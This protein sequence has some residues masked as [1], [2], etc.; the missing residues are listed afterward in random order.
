MTA[1]WRRG[2]VAVAAL[3]A[4]A[5]LGGCGAGPEEAAPGETARNVRVLELEPTDITEDFEVSGPVVPVRAADLGAQESGPVVRL[6]AAKGE[7]VAAGDLIVEQD[8]DILAAELAA[9][10]A[11]LE[12]E[13]YNLDKVRKLHDAGK[14]SR[15]ELLNAENRHAAALSR[16]EVARVRHERA[17]VGAPFAGVL[18][19]RDV[20]LGELLVPGMPVARVVD[21]YTL[22]L[23][24]YLTEG[25]VRWVAAGDTA[26]VLL[27]EH[28]DTGTGTIVFVSPEAD[29]ATGKF[30]V[31]IEIPNPELRWRS[32]VIGR[33]RL[34]KHRERA[35]V[36][37]P[38]DAVLQGPAG[39]SVFVVEDGRARRRDVALG[40]YQGLMVVVDQGLRPGER[41]VV[42]GHR[43]LRDGGLVRVTETAA[44]AD[45]SLPSDPREVTAAGAATRIGAGGDP[46]AGAAEATEAAR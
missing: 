35:V 34:P 37:V 8:R 22:K 46:A 10:R 33:A 14:V 30:A 26:T 32:G 39:P 19:A 17:A 6:G 2:G 20:E 41:L 13:A 29:R 21:P 4:A 36:A 12:T 7:A 16:A 24:S 31:E 28:E 40:A 25:R 18:V 43:E 15:I 27:G 11:D 44:A 9:A 3:L 38:R 23:E 1:N 45:G 42:R 5:A